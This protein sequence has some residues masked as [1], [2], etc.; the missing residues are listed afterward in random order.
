MIKIKGKTLQ[1]HIWNSMEDIAENPYSVWDWVKLFEHFKIP[2][3]EKFY[4]DW[5]KE[6][7]SKG[8]LSVLGGKGRE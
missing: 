1:E 3:K 5:V 4:K 7:K 6:L 2:I 8:E